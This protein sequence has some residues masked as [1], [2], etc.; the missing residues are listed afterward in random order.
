M[1][2]QVTVVFQKQDVFEV[3]A[4]SGTALR[5]DKK[6][7]GTVPAGPNPLELM[8]SALG[9]CIGVY[10]KNYLTRHEVGF[11]ILSIAVTADLSEDAPMRL[12]N[13]KAV[14]TT[15]ADLK[16]KKDVF[17]KF[18][19][20]CPVHNTLLNTKEVDIRLERVS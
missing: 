17:M 18:I 20:N 6:K 13:I 5:V 14:V 15:D 8:L 12:V 19:H 1:Q 16:G 11:K 10:A 7:E 9:S 4:A 2:Q 3:Q